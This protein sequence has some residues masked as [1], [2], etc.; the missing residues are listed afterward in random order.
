[1]KEASGALHTLRLSIRLKS[2]MQHV[3]QCMQALAV[4]PQDAP[5]RLSISPCPRTARLQGPYYLWY[6][7]AQIADSWC[8]LQ[9]VLLVGLDIRS[10][11]S[12]TD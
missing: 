3:M 1:M 7:T 6:S 10:C 2:A 12:C 4:S 5:A 9:K 11:Q 8:E